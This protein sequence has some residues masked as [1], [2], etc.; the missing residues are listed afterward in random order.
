MQLTDIFKE[1]SVYIYY[2]YQSLINKMNVFSFVG[3]ISFKIMYCY[4]E[5]NKSNG[6]LSQPLSKQFYWS[7][8]NESPNCLLCALFM[9][10]GMLVLATFIVRL[11]E[12]KKKRQQSC[13]CGKI[14][15]LCQGVSEPWVCW[16]ALKYS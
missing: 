14:R 11:K 13:R 12:K 8:M 16:T 2:I 15:K 4:I 3:L 9:H 6:L 1:M 7:V 10:S 5:H